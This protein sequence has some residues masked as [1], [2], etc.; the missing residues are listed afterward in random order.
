VDD[1]SLV[2]LGGLAA[3][4]VFTPAP[5]AGVP[6]L[7]YALNPDGTPMFPS[8]NAYLTVNGP[9]GDRSAEKRNGSWDKENGCWVWVVLPNS[10][11]IVSC[12]DL[13]ICNGYSVGETQLVVN[14][15]NPIY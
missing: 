14:G 7:L 4:P 12:I 2:T 11:V 3:V 8:P 6:V 15:T 10:I 5:R 1:H 13:G 9:T